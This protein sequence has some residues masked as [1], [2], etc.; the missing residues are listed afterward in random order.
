VEAS[1]SGCMSNGSEMEHQLAGKKVE[2]SLWGDS[3]ARDKEAR[4][5]A[6]ETGAPNRLEVTFHHQT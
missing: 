1:R 6:K 5:W 2:A 4:L 3:W